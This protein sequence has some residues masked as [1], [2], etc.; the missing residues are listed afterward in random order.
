MFYYTRVAL[1]RLFA[2]ISLVFL[3]I[4]EKDL[5]SFGFDFTDQLKD[6]QHTIFVKGANWKVED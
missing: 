3:P 4:Q 6:R 1:S 5:L 2:N